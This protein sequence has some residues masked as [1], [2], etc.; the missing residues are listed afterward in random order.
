MA[1]LARMLFSCLVDADFLETEC[2]Y[3]QTERR[4]VPPR[5]NFLPV[6]VLADRLQEYLLTLRRDDTAINRLRF[7]VLDYATGKA[8]LPPGLFTLTVPT[9]GGKTLTSLSFALQHAIRHGMKRIIYVIPF[10]AI[11]EQT[12]E[13][14]RMA[15]GDDA[16]VIEHHASFDWE[17]SSLKSSVDPRAADIA[18][19]R[20]GL[21]K[22]RRAAENWDAPI[23]VTTAVQFFESLHAAR[24]S[25]CRKLHNLARSVIALDEAQLLPIPV[26]RPCLAAL[27]ELQR[28]YAAG[29]VLCTAT[30][31]ALRAQDEFKQGLDI[32]KDRELA[33][34]PPALYTRLKRVAVERKEEPTSDDA[35]AVRFAEQPRM[36]CIVNSR[37]HAH[38]L[39]QHIRKLEGATHLTT[40][41]CPRH[42][43][44]VL[45]EARRRLASGKPLRLVATSLI[46]A[47]VDIDFPEVW[48]ALAGL[49]QIAQ[50]AGRCNREGR[51]KG[52]GRTVVFT[53][54]DHKP[55]AALRAF[56]ETAQGVLRRHDD[57]LTPEAVHD[58][59]KALY[60]MKG[61]AALDGT[62]LDRD[63]PFPILCRIAERAARLDYPFAS[64]SRA[65]RMI[66]EMLEPVIVPWDQGA[67]AI[68]DRIAQMDRP[69]SSDL[70]ALQQ[71]TVPLPAN[72]RSDWLAQ[73]VLRPVHPGPRDRPRPVRR[74]G[75][76]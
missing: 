73:G 24:S 74:C 53:P 67:A 19:G 39:F 34:D 51:M 60:W 54:A 49:D 69:R 75:P 7:H 37:A 42:R 22:L 62:K 25:R 68:L 47:G 65:F 64:I 14:F 66:D 45:S 12:A 44:A 30:Q 33:P 71:Y 23:V 41:M 76:L 72:A 11:I 10:T 2:F 15:L 27:D 50:A 17:P 59:F 28:N 1:F 52:I 61:E 3:A 48:R 56:L 21:A 70:R 46:E 36:L 38:D 29:I 5:G 6:S 57:P 43:R 63:T 31:P 55:P 58:Y 13:V 40:L 8:A 35:I 20:D 4:S 16:G 18:E 9:G 26:L 32:P